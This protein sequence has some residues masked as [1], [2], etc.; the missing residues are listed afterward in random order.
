MLR[1]DCFRKNMFAVRDELFDYA[2]AGNI[3][4]DDPAYVLLRRQIN[5]MIRYGHQLTVFR[6]LMSWLMRSV[7]GENQKF[8]W[9]DSWEQALRPRRGFGGQAIDPLIRPY[10]SEDH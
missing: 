9:H 7:S 1:L 5:G 8:Q 6:V 3:S 4:F 10:E 2:A